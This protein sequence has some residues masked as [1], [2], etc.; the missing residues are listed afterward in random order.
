MLREDGNSSKRAWPDSSAKIR[1]RS[2]VLKTEF[3]QKRGRMR[4]QG[5]KC[6]PSHFR[7]RQKFRQK[8]LPPY[9]SGILLLTT[10]NMQGLL[11]I[12]L[13]C[14]FGAFLCIRLS[15]QR[16]IAHRPL[17]WVVDRPAPRI[18]VAQKST[19]QGYDATGGTETGLGD[20]RPLPAAVSSR[21]STRSVVL[22]WRG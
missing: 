1:S 4:S 7:V 5:S 21:F 22:A 2:V 14:H 13:H 3:P 15:G 9:R 16:P 6:D 19:N 10:C 20:Y 8:V 17:F 12:F 18:G 11:T